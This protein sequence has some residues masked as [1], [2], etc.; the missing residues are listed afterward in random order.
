MVLDW[1]DIQQL[2]S[3]INT[4]LT[5]ILNKP[6]DAD[7]IRSYY[8]INCQILD[9]KTIGKLVGKSHSGIGYVLTHFR[10]IIRQ[11]YFDEYGGQDTQLRYKLNYHKSRWANHYIVR[12]CNARTYLLNNVAD[13]NSPLKLLAEILGYS[14]CKP[15]YLGGGTFPYLIQE[16]IPKGDFFR[17]MKTLVKSMK[18]RNSWESVYG[19]IQ[20]NDNDLTATQRKNILDEIDVIESKSNAEGQVVHRLRY[21]GIKRWSQKIERILTDEGR[22]M[23]RE[24]I[25]YTMNSRAQNGKL[26]SMENFIGQVYAEN[27][28]PVGKKGILTL[29]SWGRNTD[30]VEALVVKVLSS[31][32][33]T[34]AEIRE[35]L[36]NTYGRND[37]NRRTLLTILSKVAIGESDDKTQNIIYRLK[38]DKEKNVQQPLYNRV[39]KE[40]EIYSIIRRYLTECPEATIKSTIQY[41]KSHLSVSDRTIYKVINDKSNQII[42]TPQKID[43]SYRLMLNH[44]RSES[45]MKM[46]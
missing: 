29:K 11:W 27:V 36:R 31:N 23:T 3:D 21:Q 25:L 34:I 43:K 6:S 38:N 42:K 22:P 24:E 18:G 26:Y 12:A 37:I 13:E 30:T 10:K 20:L 44:V 14:I 19:Q 28:I 5:F 8:G 7:I 35:V 40:R 17:E 9:V 15:L 2:K 16:D 46:D 1:S 33:F 39:G 32:L 41:V 45:T 4:I